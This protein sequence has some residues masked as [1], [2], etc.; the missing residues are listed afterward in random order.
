ML[1]DKDLLNKKHQRRSSA[2]PVSFII[3]ATTSYGAL[4]KA[5][6]RK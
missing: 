5:H 6:S 1:I 3:E 2:T 4:T